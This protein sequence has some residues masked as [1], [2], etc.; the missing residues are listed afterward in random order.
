MEGDHRVAARPWA[1]GTRT[2][3]DQ[4][5]ATGRGSQWGRCWSK[6]Q[7]FDLADVSSWELLYSVVTM[8]NNGM[9]FK[10]AKRVDFNCSHHKKVITY[11]TIDMLISLI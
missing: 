4:I 8:V 6:S 11:E 5:L 1:G 7:S 2:V 10:V 3:T 9:Y